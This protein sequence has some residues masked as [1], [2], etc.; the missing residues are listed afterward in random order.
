MIKFSFNISSLLVKEEVVEV[1][2]REERTR[3]FI[4]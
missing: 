2:V 1:E 4:L 3:Y